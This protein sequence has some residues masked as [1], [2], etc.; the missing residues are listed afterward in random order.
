MD[1]AILLH[2]QKLE[3]L[4][5]IYNMLSG[6]V[7]QVL[8]GLTSILSLNISN[9]FFT[10]GLLEINAYPNLVVLNISDALNALQ[11]IDF[12]MNHFS[13]GLIVEGLTNCST[14]LQ[15]L[16]VDSNLLSGH[17]PNALY[18]MSSLEQ[19]SISFNNFSRHFKN[20]PWA[21]GVLQQCHSLT[22][23][24]LTRNFH[25]EEIPQNI[26]E[27]KNL[28]ILA[29]GNCALRGQIPMWLMNTTRL[30]CAFNMEHLGLLN[31]S[32]EQT[33]RVFVLNP[34]CFKQQWSMLQG[35]RPGSQVSFEKISLCRNS[36]KGKK[37]AYVGD[38]AQ[39]KRGILML[40]Y[41]IEH[42]IVTNWADMEKILH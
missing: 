4:D 13:E 16:H 12:S 28:M 41:P 18:L 30:Q 24:I 40:K 20:F 34:D 33:Y 11:I 36:T 1:E 27:F 19:L 42:G 29:V 3:V 6:S 22:T 7:S 10:G 8:G 25:R 32:E 21:L 23:L 35:R 15:Q 38:D 39:S 31:N 2:K 5:L 17:L 37:D 9:N 14:T 26:T